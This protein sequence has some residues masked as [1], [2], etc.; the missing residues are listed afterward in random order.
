[1]TYSTNMTKDI[2]RKEMFV[3]LRP[4]YRPTS[5]TFF[6]GSTYYASFDFGPVT[7]LSINGF[8][9]TEGTSTTLFANQWYYS[10]S[11]GRIYFQK[12]VAPTSDDWVVLTFEAYFSTF[13]TVWY[14]DP[15]DSST[16]LVHWHGIITQPPVISQADDQ[17]IFGYS[18]VQD[19]VM[20]CVYDAEHMQEWMYEITFSKGDVV[21]YH[22]VGDLQTANIVKIFTGIGGR[23]TLTDDT[24]QIDIIDKSYILDQPLNNT[25]SDVEFDDT[26]EPQFRLT[27]IPVYFGPGRIFRAVCIDYENSSPTTSD[28][29]QWVVCSNGHEGVGGGGGWVVNNATS[30]SLVVGTTSYNLSGLYSNSSDVGTL[31]IGIGIVLSSSA[32]SSLG[33]GTIN[34][35]ESYVLISRN[36]ASVDQSMNGSAFDV[37]ELYPS[38]VRL[39]YHF[40]RSIVGLAESEINTTSFS[41][42]D[43]AVTRYCEVLIPADGGEYPTVKE[44]ITRLCA[45]DFLRTYFDKDGKFKVRVIEPA[46]VSPD[47]E[48]TDDDLFDVSYSFDTNDVSQVTIRWV[49]SELYSVSKGGFVGYRRLPSE[50]TSTYGGPTYL[51]EDERERVIYTYGYN[52][53]TP[54]VEQDFANKYGQLLGQRRGLMSCLVKAGAYEL[55]LG[56]TVKITRKKQPGYAYDGETE[57]ARSY[58]VT[59]IRKQIDGVYLVLDDQKVIEEN[60]GD[61]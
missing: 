27:P 45:N 44:I 61:W 51:Y 56:D 33:I 16:A 28:N 42:A 8:V 24:F 17:N 1:M 47:L 29:R 15:T 55:E 23:H 43:A 36:G 57:N 39:I 14:K 35:D 2:S 19:T 34:P 5:F 4:R 3:I 7:S 46:A 53:G 60:S 30:A 12:S 22:M 59:Q 37:D 38:S 31:G 25:T 20:T 6:S 48:L 10:A 18:P 50:K 9:L 32:E 54:T 40:L 58:V 49:D 21:V 26:V 13:D 41:T 52:N 11:E